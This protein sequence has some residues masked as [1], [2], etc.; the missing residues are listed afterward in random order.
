MRMLPGIL[1]GQTWL[2]AH[3]DVAAREAE[4][5]FAQDR[6]V[7]GSRGTAVLERARM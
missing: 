2:S 6:D 3:P 7:R 4:R 5:M 1:H